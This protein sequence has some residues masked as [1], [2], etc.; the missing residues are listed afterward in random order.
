MTSDVADSPSAPPPGA[1][2]PGEPPSPET[3]RPKRRLGW[4]LLKTFVGAVFSLV[5]LVALALGLV[6]GALT[7]ERG[8]AY[9]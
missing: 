2:P 1:P 4:V 8:T 9:A 6:Y 7:T 5:L 3:P